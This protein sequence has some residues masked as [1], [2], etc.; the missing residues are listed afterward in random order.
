MGVL[1]KLTIAVVGT[2]P[3]D[4][5]QIKA[6]IERNG[7]K[8]SAKITKS[9]THLIAS[10]EAY[11]KPADAVQQAHDLNIH[12]VSYDWFDDS[13]QAKKKLG[14]RK[15]TWEVLMKERRKKKELKRI[16]T[17]ADGSKF[18]KGCENI[19]GLTGSGTSKTS[20]VVARKPRKSKSFFF[21][22]SAPAIAPIPF[23]SAK[24]DLLRRRAERAAALAEG[25]GAG[26]CESQAKDSAEVMN[27]TPSPA[28]QSPKPV[29]LIQTPLKKSKPHATSKKVPQAKISHWKED[30]HYYQD[31][32]GFEYKILLVRVD[33]PPYGSANYHIGLLESHTKPHV[34][35]AL[36][37]YKPAKILPAAEKEEKEDVKQQVS[38]SRDEITQRP[39]ASRLLSIITKPAPTPDAPY[40]GEL[41]P[42]GSDFATAL[43]SFRHA[44]RDLTLLSWEERFDDD[45]TLQK[46]R[47]QL[48]NIEPFCMYTGTT[49]GLEVLGDISDTYVR[50]TSLLPS[51]S[52]P[53]TRH[54]IIGGPIH[55][56]A[57]DARKAE[58]ARLQAIADAEEVEKRKAGL[59]RARDMKVNHNRPMF[60]GPMGRPTVDAYGQHI[61]YRGD[62]G[63][64]KYTVPMPVGGGG[65]ANRGFVAPEFAHLLSGRNRKRRL[66]PSER[67]E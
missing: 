9:V 55:R 44:F 43:R 32:D 20:P 22:T 52:H 25:T 39:E 63:M 28:S 30:Y 8:Y 7:G 4:A 11:K 27:D 51:I 45:K 23:V 35:W 29:A 61:S 41:C 47:A 67:L 24:E 21:A 16:G 38:L 58:E 3:H 56:D 34:Y 13:L 50:G 33:N 5:K 37:Q 42:R 49:T 40:N 62:G 19:E 54:G 17:L 1:D 31:T 65:N 10:K 36:V 14:T 26:A 18:R 64:S 6:W 12:V 46:A 2:H 48:L 15:Y 53:L 57:E 66:F 60:N 59:L